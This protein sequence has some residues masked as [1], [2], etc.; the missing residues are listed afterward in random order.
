M[1]LFRLTAFFACAALLFACNGEEQ[2]GGNGGNG[3][4]GGGGGA[5]KSNERTL[6]SI[7][8]DHQ[9][10]DATI[11]PDGDDK[12][13]VE[14]ML[15]VDLISDLSKVEIT[16][17]TV[18]YG[19]TATAQKG[20]K[21][22]LTASNPTITVTA[23]SGKTRTYSL[24]MSPFSESFAG[25]YA[26]TGSKILGGLGDATDANV[27]SWGVLLLASPEEK[28]WCWTKWT[29]K[30]YGP[31][32]NYDNYL[33][34]KCTKIN[35]DGTTEGTCV[36]YGGA[37]GKHW[38][39]LLDGAQNKVKAGQDMDLHHFYRK[40]P[41]GESTWKK[42]YAAGTIT[43]KDAEGKE[44]VCLLTEDDVE[45]CKDANKVVT[46]EDECLVFAVDG[47]TTWN[48]ENKAYLEPMLYTDFLKF[49]IAPRYFFLQIKKVDSIPAESKVI[50][51]E[52]DIS[53]EELPDDPTPDPGDEPE[54]KLSDVPG[55]YKV[56]SLMLYGGL[57]ANS[58]VD[59]K[60]KPWDWAG[61]DFNGAS[62]ANKEYDNTLSI[63]ADGKLNYGPGEDGAYWDYVY[64]D[65]NNNYGGI[66]VDLSYNYGILPHGESTYSI[67]T[68]S[69]VVTITAGEKTVYG[70]L[71]GPGEQS[72]Q[73][74]DNADKMEK[75]TIP[76]GCIG[77]GFQMTAYSGDAAQFNWDTM[78]Y[79]DVDRFLFHPYYYVMVFEKQ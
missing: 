6:L 21:I 7:G 42:D 37:D 34:V 77:V 51:D 60:S 28:S 62:N 39:C 49:V 15:A 68:E 66:E 29:E 75:L 40:I 3:G 30:G 1:K 5:A 71:L 36:N 79:K 2:P 41:I 20:D 64:K 44:T 70:L 69:M 35:D 10:G 22:D 23:E 65:N 78:Q 74:H 53:I 54:F 33:E 25:C 17:L 11:T 50:G 18:S 63:G 57:Y 13:T 59:V 27:W 47:D 56:K 8:F 76:A 12:G 43:F 14:F 73:N 67:N 45:I 24:M 9:I 4:N 19:A 26:I 38:N 55:N 16:T 61:Y 48:E 58:F 46:V 52:G 31:A 32:A 72:V